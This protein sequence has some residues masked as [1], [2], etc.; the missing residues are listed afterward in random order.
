MIFILTQ[1]CGPMQ[2]L[3]HMSPHDVIIDVSVISV[4][5]L[6]RLSW[7][8][9]RPLLILYLKSYILPAVDYCDIVWDN[10]NLQ[11]SSRLQS[12]FNFA[13]RL[14]LHRPRLTSSTALWKELGLTSLRTRRKL[15]VAEMTYKCHNSLAPVY[16]SSL[17]HRPSHQHNTRSR[18]LTTLP[19]TRT[20]YGQHAFA[21]IGASLVFPTGFNQRF[22]H[23]QC[24][25]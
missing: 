5:L 2:G 22:L 18:N 16:L 17:F 13:C 14:V 23:L 9:P 19:S 10:C 1:T 7:F 4:N 3:P 6:R 24:L 25:F 11:D 8:L 12:L 15:H 21:F 20:T